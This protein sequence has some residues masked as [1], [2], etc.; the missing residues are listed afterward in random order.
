MLIALG[1]LAVAVVALLAPSSYY[2]IAPGGSYDIASRLQ[3][4]PEHREP[5]GQ[6][7]FT[8]VYLYPGRWSDVVEAWFDPAT[9]TV[10]AEQVLPSG[11]SR[12]QLNE[13][14]HHLI[15]ES[16]S[17]AA[18][19]A[20]SAA[21]YD[22]KVTGQ[23]ALVNTVI[24]GMPADGVLQQRDVIVAVDGQA[25]NTAVA[26]I[27]RT[28]RHQV[29]DEVRMGI[30]R[31]GQR[32]E[33]T[34]GTRGSPEEPNRPMVGAAISTYQFA[35]SLP[36]E[37]QIDTDGVGGPSAGTMFA[38]GI[39]DAVTEGLLTRGHNVA[40]TGT[41]S[42]DGT[43]GPIDGAAQKIVAAERANADVFLV[44]RDNA[45]E[46][47]RAAHNARVV[48]IDR[49]EDA[50][51]ALCGLEPIGDASPEPPPPCLAVH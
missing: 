50:V 40:G 34:V 38:L 23:G 19:V 44:P 39:L 30:V 46:A 32:Q 1:M 36:F 17:V 35:V 14:N 24:D 37:V 42:A 45:Q 33:V 15:D 48:P 25:V 28:R 31:N 20:L 3:V 29:G 4:P 8:A 13:I 43:V 7:S 18:V 2:V 22:A 12:E 51:R 16:K 5:I 21:G 11:I 47:I 49:F 9:D 41:I 6:L 10:P 27:E 26:V